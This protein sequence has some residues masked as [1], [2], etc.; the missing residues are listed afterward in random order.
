MT[1]R[2][3]P[4]LLLLTASALALSACSGGSPD[5]G[6]P[7]LS[8]IE[9]YMSAGQGT[10]MSDEARQAEGDAWLLANEELIAACMKEEGFEYVPHAP[11]PL[12]FDF[13][14]LGSADLDDPAWIERYGYGIVFAPDREEVAITADPNEEIVAGLSDP[15]RTAYYVALAGSGASDA[16]GGYDPAKG[17]CMGA[18]QLELDAQDP[19]RGDEFAPLRDAVMDFYTQLG[20]QPEIVEL[21]AAWAGCMSA[22]GHGPYVSQM[23]PLG[24][25]NGELLMIV[26]E[27]GDEAWEDARIQALGAREI[28]LA[29]ADLAC[30]KETD[31]RASYA[32][33]RTTLEERFVEDNL[34]DLEAFKAAAEQAGSAG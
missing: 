1:R 4:T 31:Y 23:D 2:S 22:A 28:E 15:E 11:T 30:R 17:G 7:A 18:A 3:I 6:A 13:S 8:P 19:L 34:A 12:G 14:T 32:S 5:S 20:T 29:Q 9:V 33:V 27:L 16:A 24:E 10:D 25:V 26:D 21:D